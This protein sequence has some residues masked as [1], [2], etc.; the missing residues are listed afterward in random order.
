MI[1]LPKD[2]QIRQALTDT[3]EAAKTGYTRALPRGDWQNKLAF[4][5]D[6]STK[7]ASG[8]PDISVMN[9][10]ERVGYWGGRVAGDLLG[11][12]TR[13]K[14]WRYN[15]PLAWTY[16]VGEHAAK[17][18]GFTYKQG[19]HYKIDPAM[20]ALYGGGLAALMTV[21]SGNFDVQNLKDGGRPRGYSATIPN[22]YDQTKSDAP[23]AEPIVGW[24]LGSRHKLLPY[25][26]FSQ[27]R[28]DVPIEK[29][30]EYK[31]YQS[32]MGGTFFGLEDTPKPLTSL[33]GGAIGTA[34]A[35]RDP[36]MRMRNLVKGAAV[37]GAAGY[38]APSVVGGAANLGVLK[39]TTSNLDNEPEL[40][41]MGFKVPLSA[42]LTTGGAALAAY[43]LGKA[44]NLN[45]KNTPYR[46]SPEWRKA[47][48]P[49]AP[50]QLNL[51]E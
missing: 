17:Q 35:A 4:W 23:L 12:I 9:P 29:Y 46:Q 8:Q 45:K 16:E 22:P 1:P 50:Q 15:H 28:P 39:G 3:V 11:E 44:Y 37:G 31:N 21:A 43:G 41:F 36:K 19:D 20:A 26:Q 2:Q 40:Q 38:L 18:A 51:F 49:S 6:S 24:I 33:I 14:W 42:A 27:E 48:V 47:N 30:Q 25:D 32:P 7:N 34:L 10:Q 5:Q 13:G